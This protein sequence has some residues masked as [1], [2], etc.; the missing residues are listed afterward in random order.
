MVNSLLHQGVG[1]GDH[2]GNRNY[3]YEYK[4]GKAWDDYNVEQQAMIVEDWYKP[5]HEGNGPTVLVYLASDSEGE[6]LTAE[7]SFCRSRDREGAASPTF[8]SLIGRGS[9]SL[10]GEAPAW[11]AATHNPV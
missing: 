4:Y 3:A 5:R 10:S 11:R 7:G 9:E 2:H 8:R 6:K 1:R